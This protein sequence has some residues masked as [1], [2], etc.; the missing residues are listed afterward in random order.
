VEEDYQTV[1]YLEPIL[2]ENIGPGLYMTVKRGCSEYALSFF[3]F[4]N[5]NRTGKQLMN[6]NET[7]EL[8]EEDYDKGN[9]L[10]SNKVMNPSLSGL[11]LGD[12]LVIRNWVDYAKGI[13]DPA[14]IR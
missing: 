11:T 9:P 3:N 8:I 12:V 5:I 2:K 14:C 6:Y 13:K 7:W 1:N 10:Q 4:N